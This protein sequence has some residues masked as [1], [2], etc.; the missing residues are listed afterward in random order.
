[1]KYSP[2]FSGFLDY[3]RLA[4]HPGDAVTY[5]HFATT[6]IARALFPD[7]VPAIGATAIAA[8]ELF[9]KRGLTGGLRQMREAL[10]ADPAQAWSADLERLF[11]R[12]LDDAAEFER[13]RVP[14]ALISDFATGT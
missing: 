6:A 3:L 2:A 1:M 7:G 5:R 4:D 11:L 14:T 9:A 8:A 13:H 12:L 10:P